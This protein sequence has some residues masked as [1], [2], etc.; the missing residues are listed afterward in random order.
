[1]RSDHNQSINQSNKQRHR[2]LMKAKEKKQQKRERKREEEETEQK[3]WSKKEPKQKQKQKQAS[4]SKQGLSL[5]SLAV[6]SLLVL[7][8]AV[9]PLVFVLC[10]L[11]RL[12]ACFISPNK[13]INKRE[14]TW[15]ENRQTDRLRKRRKRRKRSTE[16]ERERVGRVTH[17]TADP[18]CRS[19]CRYGRSTVSAASRPPPVIVIVISGS[20][21]GMSEIHSTR[22]KKETE[23]KR[24]KER[25]KECLSFFV[26][27][28]SALVRSVSSF[29]PSSFIKRRGK[30][31]KK[32][33]LFLFPF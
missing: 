7:L 27:L 20:G 5:I 31:G 2:M 23:R 17:I 21:N 14:S 16:R 32:E 30:E 24:K 6:A 29:I 19:A 10:K 25:K 12:L 11:A 15:F 26:S 18:P 9:L 22:L 33:I 3:A 4:K 28:L 13:A 8:H 1:M